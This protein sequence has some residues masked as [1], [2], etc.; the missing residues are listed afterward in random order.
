MTSPAPSPRRW[1]IGPF[2]FTSLEQPILAGLTTTE[3][4]PAVY[5]R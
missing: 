4:H 1:S 5:A 2:T 3:R